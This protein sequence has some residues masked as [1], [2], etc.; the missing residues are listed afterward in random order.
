MPLV[1]ESYGRLGGA[2]RRTLEVLALHAAAC[3][4]DQWAVQRLVP[5]WHA[6]LERAV[7]FATAEIAL[8]ALGARVQSIF[9]G[10]S[11]DG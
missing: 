9:G 5:R 7:T 4:R 1:F 8:L 10:P 6:A 11:G 3:V 2:G